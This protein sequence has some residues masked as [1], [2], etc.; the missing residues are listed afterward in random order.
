MGLRSRAGKRPGT[1]GYFYLAF[2]TTAVSLVQRVND[3]TLAPRV[4]G[5]QRHEGLRT[6][7]RA[8]LSATKEPVTALLLQPLGKTDKSVCF[9]LQFTHF[10]G[11]SPLTKGKASLKHT[12][13]VGLIQ[14]SS[15]AGLV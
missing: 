6:L 11:L 3:L 13:S 14:P 5:K 4:T 15:L 9:E 2:S 7:Q 12:H 8:M 10:P 1:Q